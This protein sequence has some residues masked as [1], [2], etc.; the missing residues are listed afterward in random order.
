C[1]EP[2]YAG[3]VR[4]I[5]D[6]LLPVV[7]EHGLG[8]LPW[9]PLAGGW[10]SGRYRKGSD[11]PPSTRAERLPHRFDLSLPGN[12]AK[13]DAAE[14]LAVLAEEAGLTLIQLA[15]AFVTSHPAVTSAIIGPRTMS[16]LEDQL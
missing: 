12:Q 7:K 16:H 8:V 14:K 10:L 11:L 3:V 5:D 6:G 15:L 9:S 1:F 4:G 13:L 2:P